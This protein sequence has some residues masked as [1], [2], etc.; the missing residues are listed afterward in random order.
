MRPRPTVLF[1][2]ALQVALPVAMLVDRWT[3]EGSRPVSER[4]A[5]W[6]MYS[7]VPLPTYVGTD[8]TGR[9]RPLDVDALPAVVRAVGTGRTVPDQ[10]CRRQPDIVVVRRDGGRQPGVFR[11]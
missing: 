6:Q 3:D 8:A 7:A 11:C 9:V 2:V 1:V 4:P 5:S 10:L